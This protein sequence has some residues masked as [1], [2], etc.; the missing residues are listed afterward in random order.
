MYT[1]NTNGKSQVAIKVYRLKMT[2]TANY[3]PCTMIV[4]CVM[5]NLIFKK[6]PLNLE[7]FDCIIYTTLF[8]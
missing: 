8:E 3:V 7:R 6:K 4:V 5:V 2:K 1:L